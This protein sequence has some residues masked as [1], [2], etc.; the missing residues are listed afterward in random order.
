MWI[1][2]LRLASW[3]LRK[4]FDFDGAVFEFGYFAVGVKGVGGEDVGGGFS[5][6]ERDEDAAKFDGVVGADGQTDGSSAAANHLIVSGLVRRPLDPLSRFEKS[7]EDVVLPIRFSVG[8][9]KR[10]VQNDP[11]G[12]GLCRPVKVFFQNGSQVGTPFRFR[13]FPSG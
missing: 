10:P 2:S 8:I 4:F 12:K 9:A 13:I 6:V 11:I 7:H 3:G 5:E 1:H